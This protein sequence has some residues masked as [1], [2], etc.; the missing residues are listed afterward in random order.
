MAFHRFN[1]PFPYIMPFVSGLTVADA[2]ASAA[3]LVTVAIAPAP[4]DTTP[5]APLAALSPAPCIASP[6]FPRSKGAI[7]RWNRWERWKKLV[8]GRQ[9]PKCHRYSEKQRKSLLPFHIHQCP[10]VGRPQRLSEIRRITSKDKDDERTMTLPLN[11]LLTAVHA[12]RLITFSYV[13]H[14]GLKTYFPRYCLICPR[15]ATIGLPFDRFPF[16]IPAS[17]APNSLS[18][19]VEPI[20]LS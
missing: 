7:D 6:T 13:K 2:T 12:I 10:E 1:Q 11:M 19:C 3:L 16:P 4:V 17:S 14:V 5:L 20:L 18:P 15:Y 9:R 8:L